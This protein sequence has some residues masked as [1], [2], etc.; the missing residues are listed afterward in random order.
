[1]LSAPRTVPDARVQ[2]AASFEAMVRGYF[3]QVNWESP[4]RLEARAAQL[5]P[6]LMLARVDGKS[7]VEYIT[8]EATRSMIRAVTAMLIRDPVTKL[9]QV[10]QA[11][12]DAVQRTL[13]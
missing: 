13:R 6:A 8:Q 7:P 1:M 5:L 3:E 2:L 4:E 10:G 12:S 11:W 9:G